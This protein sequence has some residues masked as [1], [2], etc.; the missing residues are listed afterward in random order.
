MVKFLTFDTIWKSLMKCAYKNG[1]IATPLFSN[2]RPFAEPG[3]YNMEI[4]AICKLCKF[5]V[6]IVYIVECKCIVL[7]ATISGNNYI[8]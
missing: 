1:V 8:K 7:Y 4:K 2:L 5:T 6:C 3:F